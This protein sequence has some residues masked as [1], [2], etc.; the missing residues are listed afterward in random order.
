MLSEK[1]KRKRKM[2]SK[3]WTTGKDSSEGCAI[4]S[5]NCTVYSVFASV[6]KS[7]NKIAQF[8]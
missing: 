3:K 6:M 8:N 5:Q 7:H 1:K 4:A 2:W